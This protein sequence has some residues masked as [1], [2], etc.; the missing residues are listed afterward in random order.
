MA[1]FR[2]A[3]LTIG[4]SPRPDMTQAIRRALP[5]H[6]QVDERGVLDGLSRGEI[7][8]RFASRP[9]SAP[10][11]TRLSDGNAITVDSAAVEAGLQDS[12]D[13]L[14]Q[15]G[16]DAIVVLCTGRFPALRADRAWLIEPDTLVPAVVASL[17]GRGRLGVIAPM[18]SQ[19]GMVMEK[20]NALPGCHVAAAASPNASDDALV[21]AA[22][23]LSEQGATALVLDCMGYTAAHKAALQRQ[24]PGLPVFVSAGVLASSLAIAF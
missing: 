13:H 17:V 19:I 2:L 6:V 4:Q 7:E 11:I 9:G 5:A 23:S 14:E 16:A 20:W 22:Q 8:Q 24:V 12:I 15:D 1:T 21:A 18:P 3:L 10:L